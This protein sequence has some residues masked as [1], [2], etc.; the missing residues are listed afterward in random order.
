MAL[1]IIKN[2]YYMYFRDEHGKLRTIATHASLN[3]KD[4]A[5]AFEKEYMT[6]LRAKKRRLRILKDFPEYAA[7]Q[8]EAKPDFV[9]EAQQQ[10]RGSM[11]LSEMWETA[12]KYRQL[13]DTHKKALERF[14]KST[15]LKYVSDVTPQIALAY[16]T[17]TYGAGNGKTFNNNKTY[18]NTIFKLCVVESGISGSPFDSVLNMRL[19]NVEVHRKITVEEFNRLFH[20]AAEPWKTALLM[21]WHT[22]MRVSD[23]FTLKWDEIQGD[24]IIKIPNKTSRFNRSVYIPIHKE[25]QDHLNTL[26]KPKDKKQAVLSPF[27]TSRFKRV[28]GARMRYIQNLFKTCKV[29]DT[30]DGKASFHSLRATFITRCEEAGIPRSAIRGMVGHVSDVTTDNYSQDKVTPRLILNLPSVCKNV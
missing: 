15:K 5:L 19:K 10:R 22:G 28:S 1:R 20:A 2:R 21:S 3:E 13:S 14:I 18:L 17:N 24:A 11:K 8:P 30:K 27:L 26:P 12:C 29:L 6:Q 9:A 4:E 7:I 23:C 25:L 16:L